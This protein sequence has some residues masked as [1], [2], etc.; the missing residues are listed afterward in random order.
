MEKLG[1]IK[2]DNKKNNTFQYVISDKK[3]KDIITFDKNTSNISVNGI[4]LKDKYYEKD[5]KIYAPF[6]ILMK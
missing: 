5:N 4:L 3:E 6:S 2:S 1:G